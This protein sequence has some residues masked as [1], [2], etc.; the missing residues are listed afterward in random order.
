MNKEKNIKYI[1]EVIYKTNIIKIEKEEKTTVT[2][3]T[4]GLT[5]GAKIERVRKKLEKN[6]EDLEKLKE[7]E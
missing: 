7:E 2:N 1:K 4:F 3:I 5:S 6:I